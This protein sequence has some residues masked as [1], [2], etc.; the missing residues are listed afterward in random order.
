[1]HIT[2]LLKY[3]T[4]ETMMNFVFNIEFDTV[5]I[6][7]TIQKKNIFFKMLFEKESM[8]H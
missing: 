4:N 6:K 8:H 3:E 1:V 7:K 2:S 5:I